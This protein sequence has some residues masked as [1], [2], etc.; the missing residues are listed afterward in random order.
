MKIANAKL[1]NSPPK[2]I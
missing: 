2:R 1:Q